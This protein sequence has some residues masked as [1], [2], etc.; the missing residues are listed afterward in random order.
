MSESAGEGSPAHA[1]AAPAPQRSG[2]GMLFSRLQ[3]LFAVTVWPQNSGNQLDVSDDDADL[4]LFGNVPR[5]ASPINTPASA[6][7]SQDAKKQESSEETPRFLDTYS[8]EDIRG[9]FQDFKLP[10]GQ[11]K[12]RNFNQ[13]FED[14]GFKDLVFD[15]DVSDSFV[16]RVQLFNHSKTPENLLA[17]LFIRRETT[18]SVLDTKKFDSRLCGVPD[19]YARGFDT[20]L[21]YLRNYFTSPSSDSASGAVTSLQKKNPHLMQM[22][23]IEWLRFQNPNRAWGKHVPLPGQLHP[24]LGTV[25]DMQ[26]LLKELCVRKSRDGVMNIPEHWYNA[27]LYS[28]LRWPYHFLNPVFEGFFQSTCLA[29]Q[30]D[31]DEKG[32]PTVA[33]AVNLGKLRCMV[34]PETTSDPSS[35]PQYVHI[36]WVAQEQVTSVTP[37]LLNYFASEG[38]Q[39]LVRTYT[40]PELFYID[41][42]DETEQKDSLTDT[43]VPSSQ[44]SSSSS[45]S[46][47]ETTTSSTEA[48]VAH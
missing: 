18:F 37:K 16:H 27:Y 26:M 9:F 30:K 12:D 45:E 48:T 13:M 43:S 11:Y 33:W 28:R 24:G 32:L 19:Y 25:N 3:N 1:P 7:T 42:E 21:A 40:R 44:P 6:L 35:P 34:P 5:T 23:V 38:Y 17:Q 47:A 41:W 2:L 39:N 46:S 15:I 10:E 20:G 31:I 36:K 8:E 29:L 4:L 22:I 14:L